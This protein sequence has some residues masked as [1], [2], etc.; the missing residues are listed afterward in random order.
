MYDAEAETGVGFE[1]KALCSQTLP[2][3]MGRGR[4][5]LIPP[6]LPVHL[7]PAQGCSQRR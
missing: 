7:R 6:A 3:S 1:P 2:S 5:A 4:V